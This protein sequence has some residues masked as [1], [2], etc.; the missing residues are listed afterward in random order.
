MIAL[1]LLPRLA[2]LLDHEKAGVSLGD[3]LDLFS[4]MAWYDNEAGRVSGNPVELAWRDLD[5]LDTDS[6]Q[7]LAV[8]GERRFDAMLVSPFCDPLV[9]LT[10]DLLVPGRPLSEVHPALLRTHTP[11]G[12]FARTPLLLSCTLVRPPSARERAEHIK[13]RRTR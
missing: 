10:E 3:T 11:S 8:E 1:D 4:L 9:H 12:G 7:T 5:L 2:Y 6:V 13:G